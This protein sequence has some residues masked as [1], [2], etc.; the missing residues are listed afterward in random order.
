MLGLIKTAVR[1][2][3]LEKYGEEAWTT[4]LNNA[5]LPTDREWTADES[6]EDG[7]VV[8]IV[9]AAS[10]LLGAE[11]DF[12]LEAFGTFFLSF[13]KEQ[14]YEKL[15][16]ILGRTLKDFLFNLDYLHSHLQTMFPEA[17]FPHFTCNMLPQYEGDRRPGD[18]VLTYQ[19]CRGGLLVPF[20]RGLVSVIADQ[21]FHTPITLTA[22]EGT[23]SS[24]KGTIELSVAFQEP[25]R[26]L[27]RPPA[28]MSPSAFING[29]ERS[30][31]AAT[32]RLP[33]SGVIQA[34]FVERSSSFDTAG[35]SKSGSVGMRSPREAGHGVATAEWKGVDMDKV[36]GD[37]GLDACFFLRQFPWYMIFD[38]QMAFL[39]MGEKMRRLFPQIV[40]GSHFLK[41]FTIERPS[42]PENLTL[43][44]IQEYN[45]RSILVQSI[46]GHCS[47]EGD[48]MN[49]KGQMEVLSLNGG[50]GIVIFLCSPRILSVE[51]MI[52]ANTHL[53]D[54]PLH[55]ATRDLVL[56]SEQMSAEHQMLMRLEK[57]SAELQREQR[58]S[59]QL[60]GSMLP[61]FVVRDLRE[62]RRV[63]GKFHENISILFSDI[64]GFTDIS[65]HCK[66]FQVCGMLDELYTVFDTLCKYQDVYKVE[67]IGDAYM[68]AG[69]LFGTMEEKELHVVS[70]AE[71]AFAMLNGS[72]LVKSPKD[73]ER[74][75]IRVGMHSGSALSGVVGLKMP[76]Y[77]LFGDTVNMT[78][79]MESN[80]EKGKIHAS[81]GAAKLLMQAGFKCELR[82]DMEIKGKGV[83]RTYWVVA[84]PK[85]SQQKM[86]IALQAASEALADLR[87]DRHEASDEGEFMWEDL[88]DNDILD[89]LDKMCV[90]IAQSLSIDSVESKRSMRSTGSTGHGANRK[91]YK[92]QFA[93]FKR[94]RRTSNS[95]PVS[96]RLLASGSPYPARN[97][98][99]ND[100]VS[101]PSIGSASL[102]GD[103]LDVPLL[104]R[105]GS[106]TASR[107]DSRAGS[108][109]VSGGPGKQG[110][111]SPD[112]AAYQSLKG[113]SGDFS[114]MTM[115]S[116]SGRVASPKAAFASEKRIRKHSAPDLDPGL[117]NPVNAEA[118]VRAHSAHSPFYSR[119][120]VS[121]GPQSPDDAAGR[122]AIR[123]FVEEV[124]SNSKGG[125][126]L[127]FDKL[128]FAADNSMAMRRQLRASS[129]VDVAETVHENGTGQDGEAI[130]IAEE[131]AEE[132]IKKL[133]EQ[134]KRLLQE[135]NLLRRHLASDAKSS[136]RS[137]VEKMMVDPTTRWS[138]G[139]TDVVAGDSVCEPEDS[140]PHVHDCVIS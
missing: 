63:T 101:L 16:S 105:T 114:G 68:I 78:S 32:D 19:S 20:V 50:K 70:V 29:L 48:R 88:E 132:R 73:G 28:G 31:P 125:C 96:P 116:P 102:S 8:S 139:A 60:L 80:G 99:S 15:L 109:P 110:H 82:G 6:Y 1:T 39:D 90:G 56:I 131:S 98:I 18:L 134:N 47:G 118:T 3:V 97:G 61:D 137:S 140:D 117:F 38:H 55:D 71:Q 106:E 51:D 115:D 81:E 92:N 36:M 4:I 42:M 127:G 7:E 112:R 87:A 86:E 44:V 40:Q 21:L 119:S 91:K 66:P 100:S 128:A 138:K 67:T 35:S 121:K 12:V 69:G 27:A 43:E 34:G 130:H 135:N 85:S 111:I 83:C 84:Q 22:L 62:G 23:S 25:Q 52:E 11:V 41:H 57:M 53:N 13:L 9:V 108:K 129:E 5:G 136:R 10:E 76:R 75:Q 95:A 33:L 103:S 123:E 26:S 64:V 24:I 54:I 122:A 30:K 94:E 107:A 59:D 79:R 126:P 58:M 104:S 124:V 2:M 120:P 74:I 77:C 65:A 46:V 89:P 133:E 49:L 113:D 37:V 72:E 93:T 14:N 17:T 45:N